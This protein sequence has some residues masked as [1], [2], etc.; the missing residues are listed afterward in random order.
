[1]TQNERVIAW[2]RDHGSITQMEA[3][4]EFGIMRLAARISDLRRTGYVIHRYMVTGKNRYGE[5]ITYAKYE[6]EESKC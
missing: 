4:N 5:T 2:M 6:L 3:M 1:M